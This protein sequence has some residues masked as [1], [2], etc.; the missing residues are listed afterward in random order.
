MDEATKACALVTGA[1]SGIGADIARALA[2]PLWRDLLKYSNEG[3]YGE[4]VKN[5]S[6]AF[7]LAMDQVT[8]NHQFANSELARNSRKPRPSFEAKNSATTTPS[9]NAGTA[10]DSAISSILCRSP[11]APS[12]RWETTGMPRTTAASGDPSRVTGSSEKPS[13]PTGPPSGS[14][15]SKKRKRTSGSRLFRFGYWVAC[16]RCGSFATLA[17]LSARVNA[18]LTYSRSR[19]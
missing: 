7:A 1:S 2:D 15:S 3:K 8:V 12:S 18:L 19:P 11:W 10:T 5:F 17:L 16:S 6:R 14:A 4:F 13:P 9:T